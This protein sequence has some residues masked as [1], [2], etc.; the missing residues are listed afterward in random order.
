MEK[1]SNTRAQIAGVDLGGSLTKIVHGDGALEY[2]V[3]P[4]RDLAV[5]IAYLKTKKLNRLVLTGGGSV[6]QRAAFTDFDV[7]TADEF[8]AS[9]RGANYL[10]EHQGG[11]NFP[12]ALVSIGT[13]TSV[14]KV[15]RTGGE[16]FTGTAIGGGTI[17]GLGGLLTA[18][19]E[20]ASII[21]K[22]RRGDRSSVDIL[23][24]DIYGGDLPG[25]SGDVTA[26]NFGKAVVAAT[27]KP[28]DLGRATLQMIGEVVAVIACLAAANMGAKEVLYIGASLRD[29]P[30]LVEVLESVTKFMRQQPRFVQHSEHAGAVGAWLQ[31]NS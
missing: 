21:A 30:V 17:V 5:I 28:E 23:V 11:V 8:E 9:I 20:Y 19:R 7:E 27:A 13:G 12:Y 16:R 3:L 15:E 25:L 31:A 14:S 29:N 24:R 22:A 2:A 1:M 26:S 4:S 18:E 10:L 6:K